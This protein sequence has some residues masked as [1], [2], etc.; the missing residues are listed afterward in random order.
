[1]LEKLFSF[2]LYMGMKLAIVA[3]DTK[4]FAKPEICSYIFL[5]FLITDN[6][7]VQSCILKSVLIFFY[8]FLLWIIIM[9]TVVSARKLIGSLYWK[10]EFSRS[11][12]GRKLF[13]TFGNTSSC[14][15]KTCFPEMRVS[16]ET[17][18]FTPTEMNNWKRYFC[19]V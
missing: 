15:I 8:C 10:S 2:M 4:F 18:K 7:Y 19:Y 12:S 14:T 9:F 5:L 13:G 11:I 1:M 6:Y 3:L 17:V 16:I